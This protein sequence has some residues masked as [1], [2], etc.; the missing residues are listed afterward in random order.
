[1]MKL[2]L[3]HNTPFLSI[4]AVRSIN[5]ILNNTTKEEAETKPGQRSL[6]TPIQL[7]MSEDEKLK[8]LNLGSSCTSF[9]S[10][11]TEDSLWESIHLIREDV[12]RYSVRDCDDQ[13]D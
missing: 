13:T 8:D 10:K 11:E 4:Q 1:M 12:F 5:S 2:I 7:L 9:L 6:S 3:Y